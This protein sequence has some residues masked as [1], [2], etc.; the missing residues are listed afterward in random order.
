MHDEINGRHMTRFST[1]CTIFWIIRIAHF[2]STP[3]MGD[4]FLA[5]FSETL[6]I[7]GSGNDRWRWRWPASALYSWTK[8]LEMSCRT[9]AHGGFVI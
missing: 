3:S 5:D 8:N 2:E 9:K 7:Y 6:Q 4:I 1:N